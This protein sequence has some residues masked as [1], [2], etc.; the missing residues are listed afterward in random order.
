MPSLGAVAAH[1]PRILSLQISRETA[2]A[3][4]TFLL[5]DRGPSSICPS[6]HPSIC[7]IDRST[8]RPAL[9]ASSRVTSPLGISRCH[10]VQYPAKHFTF[11][12]RSTD[13]IN[14]FFLLSP[15]FLLF[16]GKEM[17]SCSALINPSEISIFAVQRGCKRD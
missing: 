7:P 14:A 11:G 2:V 4:A 3:H 13:I 12:Y 8:Q 6:V 16:F 5:I 1:D 10:T 15:S 17:I 9:T